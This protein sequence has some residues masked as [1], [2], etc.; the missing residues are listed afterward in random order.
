MSQAGAIEVS[1]VASKYSADDCEVKSHIPPGQSQQRSWQSKSSIRAQAEAAS[2]VT[3]GHGAEPSDVPPRKSRG[4]RGRSLH[5][6]RSQ[7]EVLSVTPLPSLPLR[8]HSEDMISYQPQREQSRRATRLQPEV[9]SVAPLPSLPLRQ[10][11]EDMISYQP[12]R[13]QSQRATRLQPEV[14]SVAPLPSLL[15]R[16]S[17]D[18]GFEAV[19]PY[20]PQHT[21]KVKT[22]PNKDVILRTLYVRLSQCHNVAIT[23]KQ[24]RSH[25][26]DVEKEI[27]KCNVIFDHDT[28]LPKGYAF[29]VFKTREAASQAI[30]DY[31]GTML[32][33][34]H[35]LD[36]SFKK[37]KGASAPPS[38]PAPLP[39]V[40]PS[41]KDDS[42]I[43]FRDE[44][45]GL[46]NATL[47]KDTMAV[48]RREG[49][50]LC[51]LPPPQ[52][53]F[54]MKGAHKG[55][56]VVR[57]HFRCLREVMLK[58][59]VGYAQ[60]VLDDLYQPICS[61]KEVICCRDGL[62]RDHKV[63]TMCSFE[64]HSSDDVM[65]SQ[66]GV[67]AG[68]NHVTL[69][70]I[71]VGRLDREEADAIVIPTGREMG[72]KDCYPIQFPSV[73]MHLQSSTLRNVKNL[74]KIGQTEI[75]DGGM[76]PCSYI[77]HALFPSSAQE[78]FD[79]KP[80]DNMVA[81]SLLLATQMNLGSITFPGMKTQLLKSIVD[82]LSTMRSTNLHTVTVVLGTKFEA[83][84]Y[85][86]ILQS[87]VKSNTDRKEIQ[88]VSQAEAVAIDASPTTA[89]EEY[90]WSW[91]EDDG[92]Q[93]PYTQE[94]MD[95]LNKSYNKNSNG[96]CPLRIN[97]MQ[98]YV[99]FGAMK[100]INVVTEKQR[101]VFKNL[102]TV[103]HHISSIVAESQVTWNYRGDNGCFVPYSTVNCANI[104][105]MFQRRDI[106]GK[107]FVGNRIYNLNFHRMKQV[108]AESGYERDIQ[109]VDSTSPSQE[110]N[111]NHKGHSFL[112]HDQIVINIKG[113]LESLVKAKDQLQ[114]KIESLLFS[115]TVPFPVKVA[116]SLQVRAKAI[117][118]KYHISCREEASDDQASLMCQRVLKLQGLEE[119]VK[120]VL[121][122][123]QELIITFQVS[124]EHLPSAA[125]EDALY[126]Q[127][128]Q[129]MSDTDTVMIVS[130][131]LT[132]R[133]CVRVCRKFAET[134]GNVYVLSVQRVQNKELWK[135][136]VQ[137]LQRLHKKNAG[138]VNEKKLFHGTRKNPA[139]N[140]CRSEEG[141]DMRFSREGMWGQ[142][143]YFAVKAEY[144]DSYAYHKD[145]IKELIL[146]KV[147]TGDSHQCDPN[148]TLRMPPE[149][150]QSMAGS[151]Q[152]QQ[153]RY[154]SVNGTTKGSAVYMTYANDLAYPAYIIT[155][156]S[157][158]AS[159]SYIPASSYVQPSPA[160]VP[161]H[162]PTTPSPITRPRKEANN[163]SIS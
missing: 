44:V 87:L 148:S 147:A 119:N 76:L 11:N 75:L 22:W 79:S 12:Q 64:K 92:S 48:S 143:N 153:V 7:P 123:V 30:R 45:I 4:R 27:E 111:R 23:N 26:Q 37:K 67:R 81:N 25:F 116:H 139:E 114:K 77:I 117:A 40:L 14:Q 70:K 15:L 93:I 145:G 57:T 94:A 65:S 20:Q 96:M 51:L 89:S 84:G 159:V 5:A 61:T 149:K 136:Y 39:Q 50:E 71:V 141:F 69:V 128:W 53:G 138:K 162:T 115:K 47:S 157:T 99:H 113:P 33:S 41:E 74:V 28:G 90:T 88:K 49:V 43:E 29:V 110:A 104:E 105:A 1:Y 112:P 124:S 63:V 125:E 150:P 80:Y 2:N 101:R 17:E 106:T 3:S 85:D 140:I 132:H 144:S 98:Y 54:Q 160:P 31:Q 156:S 129:H 146:A 102:N 21:A 35:K 137:S 78:S 97:G 18:R 127:E 59:R 108:N 86:T 36:L 107:V 24:F 9:Q 151:N 82:G 100:Q 121:L 135:R 163:C 122:E 58:T 155:Y 62:K 72:A 8:Q 16:H 38:P 161:R 46:M 42:I 66:I 158:P 109:R 142:A 126:P 6:T 131:P 56:G 68:R 13:E 91:R 10:H 118:D 134:M 120:K 103:G 152:L 55:F 133:E 34:R 32:N 130:L 73:P 60:I 19:T 83:K 154:D 95:A 52:L